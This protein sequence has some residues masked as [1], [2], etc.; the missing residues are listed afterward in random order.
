[1]NNDRP[2]LDE[3]LRANR[4]VHAHLVAS[5]E[6]QRSPH[7]RAEN[8][9]RVDA[10]VR[11]LCT[12]LVAASRPRRAVDFGC[13][14]GFM[15]DRLV[16]HFDEIHGIDITP[17]MMARVD[18]SSGKVKL[19][20][21]QAESTPFADGQFDLATA[22]S[23]LD[24]LCDVEPFL[25]E[26]HRVLKPGGVFYADLNPNRAFMTAMVSASKRGASCEPLVLREIKGA[27]H[28]GTLYEESTGLDARTL[29]RAEPGKT[30]RLGFDAI[31][32]HAL[33]V[34]LGF[35]RIDIEPHW[36]LGEAGYLHGQDPSQADVI[37]Q[38]LRSVS[39]VA[40][41]LFKYL[42]FVFSKR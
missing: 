24:H 21:S 28:N 35:A 16:P 18:L 23:F 41:S 38:Y 33:A 37:D 4:E 6:Y 14:T 2:D 25:A 22:Y 8:I 15:I 17:E 30:L 34:R 5:G 13:G 12:S 20:E 1:M 36:F 32:V 31:E 9:A 27:L 39:P 3:T 10:V 11:H 29:E 19:V 42:R 40:E 7:F 26:V